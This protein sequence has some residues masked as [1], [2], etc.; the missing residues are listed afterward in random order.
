MSDPPDR[1]STNRSNSS[2]S[3]DTERDF[4]AT[5]DLSWQRTV[6]CELSDADRQPIGNRTD[7]ENIGVVYNP[8]NPD[9]FIASDTFV[10]LQGVDDVPTDVLVTDTSEADG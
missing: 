5:D 7:A 1:D 2:I 6:D 8:R 10:L 4:P 9:K 3:V